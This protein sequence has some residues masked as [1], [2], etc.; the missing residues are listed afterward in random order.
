M[1]I[2]NENYLPAS[3]K[4]K[5]RTKKYFICAN[6][7][8]NE[9]I[10]DSWTS[11][12]LKIVDYV[13]KENVFISILENGD[14]KDKSQEMLNEFEKK[15]NHMGIKNLIITTKKIDKKHY[16]RI[17]F[18]VRLRNMVLEP[19]YSHIDWNFEDFTI[20]FFND[21]IY[22]WQDVIKLIMT[23]DMNYDVACGLDFYDQFYDVWVSRDLNDRRLTS[24]FPYFVDDTGKYQ[25]LT[26]E[27]VRVFSCW[28]GLA[29]MKAE[30][31]S[32]MNEFRFRS[33]IS[34]IESECFLICYDYWKFGFNKILINPNI[35]FTYEYIHYYKAK[36]FDPIFNI[37]FYF[38]YYFKHWGENNPDSNNLNDS[39]TSINKFWKSFI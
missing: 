16:S 8:N 28:N 3:Y 31:F 25:V 12:L 20:L 29:V 26:G 36:Y 19:M 2:I 23:N 24:Y 27:P 32:Y 34:V 21:I 5:I 9:D 4:D 18:L 1:F 22:K 38:Y 17:D 37:H 6:L 33:S 14:S 10:M 11:E 39:F 15:L 13:G 35:K 7:F 30:P